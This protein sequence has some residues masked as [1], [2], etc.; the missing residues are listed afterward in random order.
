MRSAMPAWTS[1]AR[2]WRRR[3]LLG[4]AS[5]VA[6][7]SSLRVPQPDGADQRHCRADRRGARRTHHGGARRPPAHR[8]PSQARRRPDGTRRTAPPRADQCPHP[9][10]ADVGARTGR[11]RTGIRRV[12][13]RSARAPTPSPDRGGGRRPPASGRRDRCG[14]RHLQRTDHR[15][16]A[17][18]CRSA[19]RGAH[20]A[21]GHAC[22]PPAGPAGE[23]CGRLRHA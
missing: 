1:S 9:P 2:V 15:G 8:G 18:D 7:V 23:R 3:T 10:R 22:T 11:R 17:R 14:Q 12:A 16:R 20:R 4:V 13:G 5:S 21:A 19:G 6:P